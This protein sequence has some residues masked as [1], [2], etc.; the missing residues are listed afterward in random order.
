ML[1]EKKVQK[2]RQKPKIP[3]QIQETKIQTYKKMLNNPKKIVQTI[4]LIADLL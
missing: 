1:I 3:K 4:F 2:I